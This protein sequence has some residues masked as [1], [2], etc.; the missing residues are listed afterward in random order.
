MSPDRPT[1]T[2]RPTRIGR[3]LRGLRQ[4]R[5]TRAHLLLFVALISG[6]LA[7][8]GARHYLAGQAAALE[9]T[10]R[11]EPVLL[12]VAKR[13][14]PAGTLLGSDVLAQRE[15]PKPWAQSQAVRPDE[16]ARVEGERLGQPLRSGEMLMWSHLEGRKAASFS[17]R[18]ANGRRAVTVPV[19]EVSSISG[20]LEP[21]DRIDVYATLDRGGQR[22]TLPVL[23][24]VRVLA[25]GQRASDDSAVRNERR[26]YT[27]VTLDLE[28]QQAINLLLARESGRITALLRNPGDAT[29]L[30]TVPVDLTK[31]LQPP[32][33]ERRVVEGL[34]G[35]PVLY[36]GRGSV[37]PSGQALTLLAEPRGPARLANDVAT[38]A[39][40]LAAALHGV[41]STATA[42]GR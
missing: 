34:P 37:A 30:P 12:V 40:P 16:F 21:G 25:T 39:P 10:H 2:V 33:P 31:W 41:A 18:V 3:L 13:D 5:P 23:A 20:L 32:S 1:P 26:T 36:G 19:D 38:P 8:L 35:V 17:A 28:P 9:A 4:V 11:P 6:L 15:V 29:P 22:H 14:L 42:P 7:A 27:T 24:H